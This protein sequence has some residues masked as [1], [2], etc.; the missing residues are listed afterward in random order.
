MG[1]T[2]G[3]ALAAA[4]NTQRGACKD[5]K[6]PNLRLHSRGPHTAIALAFGYQKSRVTLIVGKRIPE[7]GGEDSV[8]TLR[9]DPIVRGHH[10]E[11]Y[12]TPLRISR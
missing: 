11:H 6:V 8:L 4:G 10:Q 1:R 2:D 9:F 7:F 5:L 3:P 12:H